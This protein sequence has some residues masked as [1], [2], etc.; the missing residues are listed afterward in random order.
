MFYT[1]NVKVKNVNAKHTLYYFW[2]ILKKQ[3]VCINIEI[4]ILL[5]GEKSYTMFYESKCM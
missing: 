4:C 2:Y 3:C 5:P 1:L